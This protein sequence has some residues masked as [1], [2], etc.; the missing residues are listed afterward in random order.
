VR[1]FVPELKD[2]PAKYIYEPWKAPI[3]DQK[4]AG[5]II[6]GDGSHHEI[7]GLTAYPKP[8]FDF[9]ERRNVC[10]AGMKNAYHVGLYGN[11]K[12]VLDGTWPK[13]FEDDAEG[14]T[15][16]E[17][18]SENEE[19][20]KRTM[21]VGDVESDYGS[22]VDHHEL[23]TPQRSRNDAKRKRTG[24]LDGFVTKPNKAK[25]QEPFTHDGTMDS[26]TP[27]YTL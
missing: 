27:Q 17:K 16:G 22:E 21:D 25:K 26:T 19:S 4:A 1:H 8:M 10:I 15:H 23:T 6:K 11:S 14:P 7:D 24:T 18:Q 20:G 13:L 12:E 5:C 3:Q 2:F 9:N